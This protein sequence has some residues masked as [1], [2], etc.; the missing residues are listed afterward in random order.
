M[1]R[2]KRVQLPGLVRHVMARGNG[3]ME[4]FLDETDYRHFTYLFGDTVEE[5]DIECWNYCLMPNHYHATI[6]PRKAN[7]SAALQRLN[8]V[9]AQWW[10]KRHGRVGHVFQG[11]FKAQ[12]VQDNAYMLSLARYVA[13]NPVRAHVAA[14]AEDWPWSSYASIVGLAP[15]PAYLTVEATLGFFG[16]ADARIQRT[17]FAEFVQSGEVVAALDDRFRSNERIIGDS[18]FKDFVRSEIEAQDALSR[19]ASAPC[20]SATAPAGFLDGVVVSL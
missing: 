16:Q 12:I 5:Y 10:N 19:P 20:P 1:A 6:R 7:L 9:Y 8:S 15:T 18:Q 17:K 14:R 13:L 2:R 4:I 11:R 3:R